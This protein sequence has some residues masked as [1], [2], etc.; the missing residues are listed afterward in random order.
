M[1]LHVYMTNWIHSFFITR[2]FHDRDFGGSSD[3]GSDS[4]EETEIPLSAD[5]SETADLEVM[6]KFP[7]NFKDS[8]NDV[9]EAADFNDLEEDEAPVIASVTGQ[10]RKRV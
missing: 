3:S 1:I 6:D 4:D 2:R 5:T 10:K 9:I 7:F 8:Q